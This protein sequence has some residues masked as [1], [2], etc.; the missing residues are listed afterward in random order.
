MPVSRPIAVA[1]SVPARRRGGYRKGANG[2]GAH[3]GP[4]SPPWIRLRAPLRSPLP[5]PFL[6]IG[7]PPQP[8][9]QLFVREP[10]MQRSLVSISQM[11]DPSHLLPVQV[12]HLGPKSGRR[13]PMP[14]PMITPRPL[15]CLPILLN[16]GIKGLTMRTPKA[17]SR[18]VARFASS[19][20]IKSSATSGKSRERL[21]GN[22]PLHHQPTAG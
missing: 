5:P 11:D 15:E 12:G 4:P 6:T 17:V 8:A 14:G 13:R 9:D 2:T 7:L 20:R 1:A 19:A 21:R 18:A 16:P 3:R 10:G 22:Y